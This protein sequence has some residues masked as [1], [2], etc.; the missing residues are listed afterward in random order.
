MLFFLSFQLNQL[1]VGFS[2]FTATNQI[3]PRFLLSNH[4]AEF[5]TKCPY[6]SCFVLNCGTYQINWYHLI[7]LSPSFYLF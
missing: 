7:S 3:L 2:L 4:L 1:T 5:K 6:C